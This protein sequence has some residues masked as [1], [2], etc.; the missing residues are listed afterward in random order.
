MSSPEQRPPLRR[1]VKDEVVYRVYAAGWAIV[2]WM[3]ERAAYKL[4][5]MVADRVWARRGKGVTRLE[6]N[7]ARVLGPEADEARLR[8]VSKQG[9]RNYLRYWCDAFRLETWSRRRIDETYLI[10]GKELIDAAIASGT[11]VIVALPHMG[12]WDHAGAWASGQYTGFTTVAERL[13]PER[14]FER[15]IAYRESLGMTVLPL[16]GGQGTFIGLVRRVKSGGMVC[17]VAERD[18]TDRGVAVDFFGATTKL[19]AGAAALALATGAPILPAILWYDVGCQRVQIKPALQVPEGVSRAEKISSLCQQLADAFA[20]GI[21]AHPADWH[22]LQRLWLE[23]LDPAKAPRPAGSDGGSAAV[24]G[25][26]ANNRPIEE[27]G[28]ASLSAAST[29]PPGT[30]HP[31]DA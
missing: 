16:T 9:M 1:R 14:L 24:D 13:E 12:N 19:P 2:K 3:P 28:A 22:M 30:P 18:L 29:T 17:L 10:E 6:S 5:E 15:F 20:E 31:G 25:A 7:L 4:F 8:E 21:R 26:V 11:G 23:D 27:N